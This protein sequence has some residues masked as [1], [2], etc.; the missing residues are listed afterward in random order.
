MALPQLNRI[1]LCTTR[2]LT[3]TFNQTINDQFSTGGPNYREFLYTLANFSGWGAEL[4]RQRPLPARAAGR[5][6]HARRTEEPAG[7]PEHRQA[8]FAHTVAPPLGTQPQLGGRPPKKPEVRCDS[9]PVPDVNAGLGQVGA[10][11][12][13]VVTP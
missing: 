7:Q 9:N 2:V 10:P 13:S 1:S 8:D 11:S 5:R 6:Q 12:P 4:R 3:P